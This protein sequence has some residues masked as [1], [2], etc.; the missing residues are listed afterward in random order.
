VSRPYLRR[1]AALLALTLAACSSDA[2]RK[3]VPAA[4]ADSGDAK[5]AAPLVPAS[6]GLDRIATLVRDPA[7]D[8]LPADAHEAEQVRLGLRIFRNTRAEAARFAGN[9]LTCE[10]CHLNGGQKE[11]A[12]PLVGVA[13]TF[14][15]YRARSGRLISLQDRIADCFQRSLNGTAP[16]M[17][18][19]EMMAISAYLTWLSAGQPVGRSPAWRGANAI[20]KAAQIPVE[21]LDTA[22]GRALYGQQ[23]VAC[24]GADGQGVD[25]RV[26]KPGPLWG[27]R[28]WND[29]AGAARIYTLAGYVRRAMPLGR[30]GTLSD[31][32]AQQ[33]AAY[34][35][36]QPRPK[37]AGWARDYPAGAVPP[38]AVYDPRHTRTTKR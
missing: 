10:N 22:V 33:V 16:A 6:A 9:G 4:K 34:I 36:S 35:N 13:A 14:P 24:H 3:A 1:T 38:D 27:P 18:S 7:H 15:Q 21:R 2:E 5:Q 37:F 28:S 8:S 31:E 29:G 23:C 30:G 12:L 32:Q 11:G 26:A 25:L 19:R 17:D 20:P